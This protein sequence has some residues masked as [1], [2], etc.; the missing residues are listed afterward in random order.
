MELVTGNRLNKNTKDLFR[1]L[2]KRRWKIYVI[3][4][5]NDEWLQE[6]G[7]C[8]NLEKIF[9]HFGPGYHILLLYYYY[10]RAFLRIYLLASKNVLLNILLIDQW[11]VC[12][13]LTRSW[14][15]RSENHIT[16]IKKTLKKCILSNLYFLNTRSRM[17]IWIIIIIRYFW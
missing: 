1:S 3:E 14:K 8:N 4:K 5:R 9:R 16:L 6:D 10:Y 13:N 11:L 15:I 2:D 12:I 7:N 17:Q